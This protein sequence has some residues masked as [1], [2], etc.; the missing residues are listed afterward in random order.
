MHVVWPLPA[1]MKLRCYENKPGHNAKSPEF[2][3]E[4]LKQGHFYLE[5]GF[6]D[7][8]ETVTVAENVRCIAISFL[9]GL[10]DMLAES[11]SLCR[12]YQRGHQKRWA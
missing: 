5:H 7:T 6:Q 8:I 1:S 4:G 3:V 11:F 10:S 12:Y 2:V 9:S